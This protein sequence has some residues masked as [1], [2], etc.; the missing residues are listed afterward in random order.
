MTANATAWE[1]LERIATELDRTAT[2][3][4]GRRT[5]P[6]A[7]HLL[8]VLTA[9]RTALEVLPLEGTTGTVHRLLKAL[10]TTVRDHWM[11]LRYSLQLAEDLRVELARVTFPDL[12][13][14]D[15]TAPPAPPAPPKVARPP[16]PCP[17]GGPGP[18]GLL[19]SVAGR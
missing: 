16:H 3:A 13:A 12:Q 8:N 7:D 15:P 2:G 10:E 14:S 11:E 9:A 17:A 18:S 5:R 4:G 19:G 6:D 1:T